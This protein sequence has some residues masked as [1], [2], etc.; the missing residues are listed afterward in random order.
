AERGGPGVYRNVE[1]GV[2][3]VSASSP[4]PLEDAVTVSDNLVAIRFAIRF[5]MSAVAPV[6]WKRTDA[7]GPPRKTEL[8]SGWMGARKNDPSV[9]A[10]YCTHT[11]N[12]AVV[13]L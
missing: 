11:V 1:V 10:W 12:A 5:V 4:A 8:P 9:G 6:S 7:G 2:A 13:A 3:A